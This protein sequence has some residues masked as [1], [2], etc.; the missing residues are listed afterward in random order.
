M[1]KRAQVR[2]SEDDAKTLTLT[3][4]EFR[5]RS[6]ALLDQLARRKLKRV[7]ITR[8]GQPVAE[9]LPPRTK[10]PDLWGAMKGTV[11]IAPGVDLTAPVL[12]EDEFD[13]AKGILHR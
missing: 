12:S 13:A 3:T 6:A 11:T 8:R 1:A 9:V 4:S 10:L 2:R 7:V 5:A